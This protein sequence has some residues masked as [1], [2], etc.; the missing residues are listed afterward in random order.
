MPFTHTFGKPRSGFLLSLKLMQDE[1]NF[2]TSLCLK[3][4]LDK[5]SRIHELWRSGIKYILHGSF[6]MQSRI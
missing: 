3:A 6:G 2:G 1:S 4:Y 5:N